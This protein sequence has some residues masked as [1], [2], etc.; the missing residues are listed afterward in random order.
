[1]NAAAMFGVCALWRLHFPAQKRAV[2]D[3]PNEYAG[4]VGHTIVVETWLWS[5]PGWSE[6]RAGK[7]H[8]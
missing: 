3:T 5:T 2:A 4:N 7:A 8:G 6:S 1:L